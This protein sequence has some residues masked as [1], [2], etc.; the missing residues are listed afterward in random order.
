MKFPLMLI[1]GGGMLLAG[2]QSTTPSLGAN[3]EAELAKI[4]HVCIMARHESKDPNPELK[5]EIAT[6]LS[7]YGIS[8]E[9]V[10]VD[11]NR[12]RLYS[13]ACRYN[14]RYNTS[15]KGDGVNYISLLIRTPKQAVASLRA[16]PDFKTGNRQAE[17]NRI[18]G[19]L[20]NKK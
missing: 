6:A 14:L 16:H 12:K 11:T 19:Q 10:N 3:G 20:L 13:P 5:R 7:K 9:S 18:I 1:L 15:G 4:R 2:C 17:I 8:S